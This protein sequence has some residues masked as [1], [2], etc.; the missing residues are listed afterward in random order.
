M[1]R[2]LEKE[3]MSNREVS[4]PP[5]LQ[6]LVSDIRDSLS[7]VIQDPLLPPPFVKLHHSR[8]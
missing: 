4:I 3:E 6:R 8:I 5:L 2:K 1:E 7:Q